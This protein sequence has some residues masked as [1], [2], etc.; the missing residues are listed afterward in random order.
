[1]KYALK[2]QYRK[3]ARWIFHRD[4]IKMIRKLKDGEGSYIWRQGISA[5][6]PDT[7]LDQPFDESEYQNNTFSGSGLVGILGD[8]SYYWIVDAL[9]FEIQ[10]AIERYAETNQNGYFGRGETDGMVVLADAFR[11]VKLV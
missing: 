3:N 10:V 5:D 9:N 6:K 1:M 4:A 7:I 11:R 8:F 2:A